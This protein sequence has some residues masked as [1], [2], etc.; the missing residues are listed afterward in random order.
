[1]GRPS[2]MFYTNGYGLTFSNIELF[3]FYASTIQ[4]SHQPIRNQAIYY[5]FLFNPLI[6]S[7][8]MLQVL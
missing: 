4:Y 1:M 3:I 5:Y 7:K 8:F 2:W 6:H